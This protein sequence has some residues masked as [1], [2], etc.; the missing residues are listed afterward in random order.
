MKHTI[1]KTISGALL[2][3]SLSLAT[4]CAFSVE[5]P[6]QPRHR[7]RVVWVSGVQY[8]QVYYLQDNNV[9]VVSQEPRYRRDRYN[10]GRHEDNGNNDNKGNNGKHGRD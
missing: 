7:S 3:V 4:G 9:V 10:N 2:L 5:G 8:R 6:M 1:V